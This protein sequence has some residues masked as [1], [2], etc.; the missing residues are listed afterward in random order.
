MLVT[1]P[2]KSRFSRTKGVYDDDLYR[3][4]INKTNAY[5]NDVFNIRLVKHHLKLVQPHA[6]YPVFPDIHI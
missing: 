5:R 3:D 2:N 6:C 4:Y 1:R